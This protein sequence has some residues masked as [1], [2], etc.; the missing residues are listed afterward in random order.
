[1][2]DP[3]KLTPAIALRLAANQLEGR[4]DSTE[5]ALS[6]NQLRALALRAERLAEQQNQYHQAL[7]AAIAI[8]QDSDACNTPGTTAWLWLNRAEQ[9]VGEES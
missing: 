4:L 3:H 1:M 6:P 9:L 7:T 2:I 8:F 5:E